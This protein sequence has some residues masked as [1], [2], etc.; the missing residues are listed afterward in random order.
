MFSSTVLKAFFDGKCLVTPCTT[1]KTATTEKQFA[2][3]ALH[4]PEKRLE[5]ISQISLN[6]GL[7]FLQRTNFIQSTDFFQRADTWRLFLCQCQGSRHLCHA[8]RL[9]SE[10]Q[11]S[12]SAAPLLFLASSLYCFY[13][14]FYLSLALIFSGPFTITFCRLWWLRCPLTFHLTSGINSSI[15]E[16]SRC[17]VPFLWCNRGPAI[18][19]DSPPLFCDIM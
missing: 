11:A 12:F 9:Q 18:R 7:W 1:S 13:A 19:Q 3:K 6:W 10:N 2:V 17:S 16:S 8:S 14:A 15:T 4:P 5:R